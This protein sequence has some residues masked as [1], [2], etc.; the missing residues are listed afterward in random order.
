MSKSSRDKASSSNL[1]SRWQ[2][3]PEDESRKKIM[4]T[5]LCPEEKAKVG[6]LMVLMQ[7]EKATSHQL[8]K[9]LEEEKS[10]RA[11]LEDQID[12]LKKQITIIE[13]E[14]QENRLLLATTHKELQAQKNLVTEITET[15][16]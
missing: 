12:Q 9:S 2:K 16:K 10:R 3:D 15:A 8:T 14:N 6:E 5:D 7:K 13:I 1:K 11:V 4:L